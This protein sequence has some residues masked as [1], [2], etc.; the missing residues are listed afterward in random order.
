VPLAVQ[1]VGRQVEV[2]QVADTRVEVEQVADTQVEV[3]L[4]VVVDQQSVR[5]AE[6]PYIAALLISYL[7]DVP[8]HRQLHLQ[9]LPLKVAFFF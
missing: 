1:A 6:H 5:S 8:L 2:G 3:E 7:H 9:Q 4:A